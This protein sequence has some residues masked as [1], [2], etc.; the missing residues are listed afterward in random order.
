MSS[1]SLGSLLA[2]LLRPDRKDKPPPRTDARKRHSA[3]VPAH[4]DVTNP[5]H[6][7]PAAAPKSQAK[8]RQRKQFI[9]TINE[10]EIYL[11]N[12]QN[13]KKNNK[14]G[15]QKKAA[16]K[17]TM[18]KSADDLHSGPAD[19]E[20]RKKIEN[21]RAK[22]TARR[23]STGL[24]YWFCVSGNADTLERGLKAP[25]PQDR[26]IRAENAI[27]PD[28]KGK[29]RDQT[30]TSEQDKKGD[31]KLTP[32]T[33]KPV[34]LAGVIR[35][36]GKKGKGN[37]K[38]R[39]SAPP[40]TLAVFRPKD[41]PTTPT[42]HNGR[43]IH[44]EEQP[45]RGRVGRIDAGPSPT[46]SMSPGVRYRVDGT[47]E[48]PYVFPSALTFGA[49]GRK[50]RL[51]SS[52][53]SPVPEYPRQQDSNPA[54]STVL[55]EVHNASGQ[56]KEIET[57][58]SEQRQVYGS[59]PNIADI[60]YDDFDAR[61]A[62]YLKY[63][64]CNT[65]EP[66]SEAS[67]R[68][69]RHSMP[70]FPAAF[71][72]RSTHCTQH[73]GSAGSPHD[74]TA[75]G[76]EDIG[77]SE[78]PTS[79]QRY[80]V[81]PKND[82]FVYM[83]SRENLNVWNEFLD[84]QDVKNCA[85]SEREADREPRKRYSSPVQNADYVY[86]GSIENIQ[87]LNAD[88]KR[89]G[90]LSL[91]RDVDAFFLT[92][93][94]AMP[95]HPIEGID[96][97]LVDH[98]PR[99]PEASISGIGLQETGEAFAK[100]TPHQGVGAGA[101]EPSLFKLNERS[102]DHHRSLP[103]LSLPCDKRLSRAAHSESQDPD[104]ALSD[105][106]GVPTQQAPQPFRRDPFA[107]NLGRASCMPGN[108]RSFAPPPA[109]FSQSD[110]TVQLAG[111]SETFDQKTH[112]A[113]RL[114]ILPG[115]RKFKLPP[116]PNY[117]PPRE[118]MEEVQ[119]K[120]SECHKGSQTDLHSEAMYCVNMEDRD[121]SLTRDQA[122]TI[123]SSISFP[124]PACSVVKQDSSSVQAASVCKTSQHSQQSEEPN[125][126]VTKRQTKIQRLLKTSTSSSI[127][128]DDVFK[129]TSASDSTW[130]ADM[131]PPP[132][133]GK[134]N[135]AGVKPNY[136]SKVIT[137]VDGSDDRKTNIEEVSN[138]P[139]QSKNK[140][141]LNNFENID[142]LDAAMTSTPKIV[143]RKKS[144]VEFEGVMIRAKQTNRP[145]PTPRKRYSTLG[146]VSNASS[147]FSSADMLTNA[148]HS[149]VSVSPTPKPE[150]GSTEAKQVDNGSK[151]VPE[152]TRSPPVPLK[153]R[154][155]SKTL[156]SSES[157]FS[158]SEDGRKSD[159]QKSHEE[160][161]TK[162]KYINNQNKHSENGVPQTVRDDFPNTPTAHEYPKVNK[163]DGHR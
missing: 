159:T 99:N 139:K 60:S 100:Q 113:E 88:D 160:S 103:E 70:V 154:N 58:Q 66:Q 4:F 87:L 97:A 75:F 129:D 29:K 82:E 9:D 148:R 162:P 124:E 141:T 115:Y 155:V 39:H 19:K 1:P 121:L 161:I 41:R 31:N 33:P 44:Q 16:E 85:V 3:P 65:Q 30:S 23:H 132:R 74:H 34:S 149:V 27:S 69:N 22:K 107:R 83:G 102:E 49:D 37:T 79:R 78:A 118:E 91:K 71:D 125:A 90:C 86:M 63:D 111:T 105:Q 92:G 72:A 26:K 68:V 55:V 40:D 119:A 36:D 146:L 127:G 32:G 50:T 130:P 48:R 95:S 135:L 101:E 126:P 140:E 10:D 2:R 137:D 84:K 61:K 153:R 28:K 96:Q 144:E 106:D 110:S 54:T 13:I 112:A 77:H 108:K 73:S 116:P 80:S 145:V 134:Y 120:L 42:Q 136:I 114:P 152:P 59:N 158:G 53:A 98:D 163:T 133:K 67:T 11:T 46:R 15:K 52:S 157:C 24:A 56:T 45:L 17:V 94:G 150:K 35:R 151:T 8:D 123:N 128:S 81:P 25:F 89:A 122:K 38:N 43:L 62:F 104:L 20:N 147:S 131:F 156:T 7:P 57:K 14:N 21:T 47:L 109:I 117:T 142:I 143:R 93:S 6:I 64:G 138:D 18:R 5:A 51:R 12:T 76:V